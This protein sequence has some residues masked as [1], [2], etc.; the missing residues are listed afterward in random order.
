MESFT[1]VGDDDRIAHRIETESREF[2][3]QPTSSLTESDNGEAGIFSTG[4]LLKLGLY[5]VGIFVFQTICAVWV[6]GSAQEHDIEASEA[7]GSELG[8]NESIKRKFLSHVGGK[9]LVEKNGYKPGNSVRQNESELEEKIVEIRS[10]AREARENERKKPKGKG[11]QS[12]LGEIGDDV[13]EEDAISTIRSGIQ[14]EVD[15]RVTKLQKR[16][17]ATRK[18]SPMSSFNY[19]NMSRKVE[20]RVNGNDSHVAESNITLMFKKKMKLRNAP[21]ISRDNPKGF[22]PLENSDL[23][24]KKRSSSSTVDKMPQNDSFSSEEDHGRIPLSKES[25]SSQK[26]R[27][28]LEKGREANKMGGFANAEFRNGKVP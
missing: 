8:T 10:M 5:L 25:S 27:K 9:S 28:K 1:L 2:V 3:I 17:D 16:L 24:K 26:C 7:K 4:S 13:T 12:H 15:A 21:S 19:S 23:S 14:E 22:K 18:K 11:S 6:L 20:D